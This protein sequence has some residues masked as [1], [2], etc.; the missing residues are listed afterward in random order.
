[1]NVSECNWTLIKVSILDNLLLNTFLKP[2]I[3]YDDFYMT[4]SLAN[5]RCFKHLL[6]KDTQTEYLL[7]FNGTITKL[8]LVK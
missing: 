7:E 8:L 6:K 3:T 4:Q 5:I 2:A 1:M